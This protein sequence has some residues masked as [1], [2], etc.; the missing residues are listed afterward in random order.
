MS[1]FSSATAVFPN[2]VCNLIAARIDDLY[3]N[4]LY[5]VKRQLRATDN[6]RSVGIAPAW[7]EPDEDSFEFRSLEPT[8][9]RYR[10]MIQ[11][12]AKNSDAELG[13]AEHSVMSK[14]IRSLL[15]RD[16]PL[17]LGLDMLSVT[18]NGATERIQ[19]RGISR[20]QYISNEIQGNWLF[21]NTLEYYVETET[22]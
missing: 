12:F 18:M 8:I 15:Y 1:I 13:I 11:L 6:T 14:V 16:G 3:H 19:R 4:D 7:W 9:Q 20:S 21:L 22:K 2:N 10:I 5:V 17:K